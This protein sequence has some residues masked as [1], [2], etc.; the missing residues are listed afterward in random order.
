MPII[1]INTDLSV[2]I[3]NVMFF[4]M[5]LVVVLHASAPKLNMAGFAHNGTV[6]K[7]IQAFFGEGITR[8]AVPAFF[9]MSGFLFFAS[10][11]GTWSN[12]KAKLR[13]RMKGLLVPYIIWSALGVGLILILNSNSVTH[14]L[15]N[16]ELPA[17]NFSTILYVWLAD[18]VNYQFWFVR[19]LMVM[20]VSCTLPL[21]FL[22]RW[23]V[24]LS[25]L[26]VLGV[27]IYVPHMPFQ[28]TSLLYYAIGASIAF[29]YERIVR[30]NMSKVWVYG[31]TL[32]WLISCVLKAYCVVYSLQLFPWWGNELYNFLGCLSVWLIWDKLKLLHSNLMWKYSGF[33]FFVFA[34]H[35]PLLTGIKKGVFLISHELP[36]HSWLIFVLSPIL[37]ITISIA[38]AKVMFKHVPK[39]Y[40]LLSGNRA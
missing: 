24:A 10:F 35:E 7:F 26:V 23:H 17:S 14:S 27:V 18:P 5:L 15:V 9:M 4:C 19:D 34:F 29:S 1:K 2:K 16:R 39:I 37:C 28:G 38:C 31:I 40:S 21:Y 3:K 11:D 8:I 33:S 13:S 20:V 12:W 36:F 6:L 32:I 25:L 30:Y 22:N